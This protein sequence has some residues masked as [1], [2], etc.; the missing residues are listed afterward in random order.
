MIRRDEDEPTIQGAWCDLKYEISKLGITQKLMG[1]C[2]W[3]L[4]KLT[5]LIKQVEEVV[6]GHR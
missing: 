6:N 5:A 2:T 1:V 4:D 3:V